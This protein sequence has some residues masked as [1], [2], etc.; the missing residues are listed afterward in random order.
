M[1]RFLRRL[2]LGLW[3]IWASRRREP[4]EAERGSQSLEWVGLGFVV[5][6]IMATAY[7]AVAHGGL[8]AGVGQALTN[9]IKTHIAQ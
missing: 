1:R 4:H 8:G 6:A 7:D 2:T 9:F 3:V 5:M